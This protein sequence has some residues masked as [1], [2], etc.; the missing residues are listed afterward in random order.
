M[1]VEIDLFRKLFLRALQDKQQWEKNEIQN[2]F[3]E[4]LASYKAYK[5]KIN[6]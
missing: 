2:L 5:D 1:D 3:R 6:M 4:V